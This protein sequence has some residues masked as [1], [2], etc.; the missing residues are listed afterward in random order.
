MAVISVPF[1][2]PWIISRRAF[3]FLLETVMLEELVAEDRYAIKQAIALDGLILEEKDPAQRT[4]LA[5]IVG[6]V[7]DRMRLDLHNGLLDLEDP[8]DELP[9]MLADLEM[10]L[11]ALYE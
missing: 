8:H 6:R 7:A 11:S 3:R 1:D 10:K 5:R 2:E 9:D 4:R